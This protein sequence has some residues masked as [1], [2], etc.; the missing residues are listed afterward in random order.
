M[1]TSTP[2]F[3]TLGYVLRRTNY[4]E[5]DR[6]LNII[7]KNGK[8][9]A[10]A[11]S[12][13]KEKSKLAGSIELF[14]LIDFNFHQGKSD[15]AIITGAKMLKH[16]GNIPKNLAKL[17]LASL[18]LKQVSSA[19][20]NSENPAYF[21]LVDQTL[22]AIDQGLS[23][24]LIETWF[25]FNLYQASGEEVNLYRDTAG[26]KLNPDK[27][28]AWDFMEKSLAKSQD[29]NITADEIKLMRLILTT[30]LAVVA[31]IKNIDELI[32]PIFP[33]SQGL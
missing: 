21:D 28:Y 3:R 1:P 32:S 14:S 10:I 16:Y 25:R 24:E 2:D 23:L 17:E 8:I 20:E 9:S 7:T 27:A 5:A 18:I 15:F 19:S 4:G 22:P 12:A 29:G 6:I 33:I 13:R 31:K 30:K 26:E 11:K